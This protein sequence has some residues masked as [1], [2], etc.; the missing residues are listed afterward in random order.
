MTNHDDLLSRQRVLRALGWAVVLVTSVAGA[1]VLGA[2][3]GGA[4][5]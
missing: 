1:M 3:I 4:F 2:A 5:A